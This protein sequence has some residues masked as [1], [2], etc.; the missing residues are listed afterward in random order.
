MKRVNTTLAVHK[1]QNVVLSA[2]RRLRLA[3]A[4]PPDNILVVAPQ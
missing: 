2:N 3:R 4:L 1:T